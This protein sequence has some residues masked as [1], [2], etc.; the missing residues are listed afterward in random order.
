MMNTWQENTPFSEIIRWI[1]GSIT[2]SA[3]VKR[4]TSEA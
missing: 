2:E 3:I 4:E 1:T